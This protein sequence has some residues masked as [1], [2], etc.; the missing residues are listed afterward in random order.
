MHVFKKRN[1]AT[2]IVSQNLRTSFSLNVSSVVQNIPE[3]YDIPPFFS[4]APL[5]SSVLSALQQSASLE[6]FDLLLCPSS[7]DFD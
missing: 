6:G 5:L 3:A 2:G 1:K 7:F 4:F